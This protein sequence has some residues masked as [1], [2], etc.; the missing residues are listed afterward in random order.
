MN[1]KMQSRQIHQ[2]AFIGVL[3]QERAS[4]TIRGAAVPSCRSAEGCR[5]PY[6]VSRRPPLFSATVGSVFERRRTP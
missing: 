5:G 2:R 4:E 1:G 6:P 3:W